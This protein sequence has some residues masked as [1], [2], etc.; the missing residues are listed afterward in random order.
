MHTAA[1]PPTSTARALR[2]AYTHENLTQQPR[3]GAVG[4]WHWCTRLQACLVAEQRGADQQV[5]TH[6]VTSCAPQHAHTHFKF[7]FLHFKEDCWAVGYVY[8][9]F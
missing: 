6:N 3:K 2:H 7:E 8:L 5:Y 9:A 4:R 1:E